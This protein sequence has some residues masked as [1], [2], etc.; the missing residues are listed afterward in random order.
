MDNK[1][2]QVAVEIFKVQT[3]QRNILFTDN[4]YLCQT[5]LTFLNYW[6]YCLT[7]ITAIKIKL[8]IID[9]L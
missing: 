3:K 1:V 4:L 7:L 5:V 6:Y 8:L 9:I 2:Y